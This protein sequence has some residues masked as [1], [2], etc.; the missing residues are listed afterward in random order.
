MAL[1]NQRGEADEYEWVRL[2]D[3]P[4]PRAARAPAETATAP[5]GNG[6]G[7]DGSGTGP[8][9]RSRGRS[10]SGGPGAG[11]PAPTTVRAPAPVAV[12]DDEE[13]DPGPLAA[14]LTGWV[15]ANPV[16]HEGVGDRVLLVDLDNLRAGAVRW[17]ARMGLVVA[18]ARSAD[19]VVISGQH[20][21]VERAVPFLAEFGRVAQPVPDG[22]DLADFVL[23]E[24]ARAVPAERRQV[25]VLSN[26]GI[27][28]ELADRGPVTVLSP[29]ADALSDRLFDAARVVI[30]L[31][32]L[33]RTLGRA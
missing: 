19:H 26:D 32:T 15:E 11:T 27:F 22:A 17:R 24:G 21:A 31:M 2:A 7:T 18:L 13:G 25:V 3:L 16:W 12:Q 1:G 10:R 6:P 9:S 28:A 5:A 30:D 23:L 20:A 33:E 4:A 14:A 8:R 29:G